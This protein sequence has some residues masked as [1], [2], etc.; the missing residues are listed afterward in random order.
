[1]LCFIM[2]LYVCPCFYRSRIRC[3]AD[4]HPYL[5]RSTYC[6]L[7]DWFHP[8]CLKVC[9]EEQ[10]GYQLLDYDKI[11]DEHFETKDYLKKMNI[12]DARLRLRIKLELVPGIKYCYKNDKK[13]SA[14][15][16]LAST[17]TLRGATV[18][19]A[20]HIPS[21]VHLTAHSG[22]TRI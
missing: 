8:V 5:P 3:V 20:S 17:L 11:K 18:W 14:S 19:I 16:G 6:L 7:Q 1:M 15:L 22:W 10:V 4:I 9:C 2:V 13:F 21:G 12:W